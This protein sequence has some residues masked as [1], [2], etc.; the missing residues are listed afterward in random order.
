MDKDERNTFL[1][2]LSFVE[3]HFRDLKKEKLFQTKIGSWIT[4]II[5]LM[6]FKGQLVLR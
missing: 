5:I 3:K 1:R 2:E 6:L 4:I